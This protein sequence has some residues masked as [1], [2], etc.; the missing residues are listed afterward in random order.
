[1][2]DKSTAVKNLGES[3]QQ[4]LPHNLPQN[5]PGLKIG[6]IGG[7]YVGGT[8][9]RWYREHGATVKVYDKFRDSDP[10]K[11]VLRQ[12][13]IFI[14]VPTNFDGKGIDLSAMDDAMQNAS[15]SSAKAV[16]IKATVWPRTSRRYFR[17]PRSS[18]WS[19]QTSRKW[20]NILATLGSR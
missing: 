1:M 13:Y 12:D 5:K 4:T 3:S 16:I 8:V 7:G 6:V 11:E 10:V 19:P 15:K 18:G 17:S 9:A 14:A 20:Q 2:E